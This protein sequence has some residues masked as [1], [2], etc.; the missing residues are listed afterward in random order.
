MVHHQMLISCVPSRKYHFARVGLGG[1][2]LFLMRVRGLRRLFRSREKH[3][4][5]DSGHDWH[6]LVALHGGILPRLLFPSAYQYRYY[7][8]AWSNMYRSGSSDHGCSHHSPCFS[9][10]WH[11][12]RT[13]V[14]VGV[15]YTTCAAPFAVYFSWLLDI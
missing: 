5:F 3:F 10:L 9:S 12:T 11:T 15:C 7:C 2:F 6:T 8:K 13:G 1:S 14:G 4:F